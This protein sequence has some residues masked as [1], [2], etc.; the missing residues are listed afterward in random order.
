MF[1]P[2]FILV[3][4]AQY[5]GGDKDRTVSAILLY[6]IEVDISYL[7]PYSF[8]PD[9]QKRNPDWLIHFTILAYFELSNVISTHTDLHWRQRSRAKKGKRRAVFCSQNWSD[10]FWKV[11]GQYLSFSLGAM[12]EDYRQLTASRRRPA[13]PL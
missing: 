10:N 8:A 3:R 1:V 4:I 7:S 9:C 13:T 2:F 11:N 6:Q 12:H 5:Y